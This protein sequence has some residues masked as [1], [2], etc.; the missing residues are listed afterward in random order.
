[1][2]TSEPVLPKTPGEALERY[3]STLRRWWPLAAA[4]VLV[5]MLTAV[6]VAMGR[7]KSYEATAK[8]L[9]GQQRQVEMVLGTGDYSPDPERE[10]NTSVQLITLEPIADGVRRALGLR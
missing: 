6:V 4:I 3:V 1:M 8:V 7:P 2:R 5:A 10:L 9:L